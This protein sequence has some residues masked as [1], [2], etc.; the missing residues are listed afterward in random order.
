MKDQ[1]IFTIIVEGEPYGSESSSLAFL[2]AKES[3]KKHIVQAVFFYQN[4]VYNANK[5]TN[6]ANDECNLIEEWAALAK[7]KNIRLVLCSAAGERR[8]ISNSV[9]QEQFEIGGLSDLAVFIDSSDK[10]IQF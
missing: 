5:F 8:G 3:V 2:F 6:P 9:L 4:G 10:V 7:Q 1:Q